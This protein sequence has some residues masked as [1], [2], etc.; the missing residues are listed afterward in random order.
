MKLWTGPWFGDVNP[1]NGNKYCERFE[2]LKNKTV[3]KLIERRLNLAVEAGCDGV[4][5]DNIDVPG[6]DEDEIFN[7]LKDMATY[8]HSKTTKLGNP[9]MIGQKNYPNLSKRLVK[10][11]DFAVLESCLITSDDQ[12]PFCNQFNNYL[13]QSP[14]KPVIDIE[15]PASLYDKSDE[16]SGCKLSGVSADD[17]N[18]LCAKGG[19]DKTPK[20]MSEILKLNYDDFGLNGCTQYCQDPAA[21]V[22]K[23]ND[24]SNATCSYTFPKCSS[25]KELKDNCCCGGCKK[26]FSLV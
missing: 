25:N 21:V 24:K 11:M 9:L 10:F 26:K 6:L 13:S 22:T 19:K 4:D 23:V 14:P 5:P 20:G 2:D 16:T 17:R 3:L 18:L 8:A 15:Y 7:V 1:G 12:K